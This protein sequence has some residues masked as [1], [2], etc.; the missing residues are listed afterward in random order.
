M[1]AKRVS[2]GWNKI[3]ETTALDNDSYA[4]SAATSTVVLLFGILIT[5]T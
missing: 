2:V 5:T 3:I 4:Q 1:N